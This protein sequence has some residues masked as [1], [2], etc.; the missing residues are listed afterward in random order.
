MDY[1]ART[2][3]FLLLTVLLAEVRVATPP[4]SNHQRANTPSGTGP[5]PII[6]KSPLA[7]QF[8]VPQLL[9]QVNFR[10]Q[11]RLGQI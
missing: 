9:P 11:N 4:R 5:H 6:F 10:I 7:R 2:F 1:S 3:I 8:L